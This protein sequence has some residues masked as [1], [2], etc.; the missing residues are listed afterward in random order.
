MRG[1][2]GCGNKAYIENGCDWC[3]NKKAE[4]HLR[5]NSAG[6]KDGRQ[7]NHRIASRIPVGSQ[8]MRSFGGAVALP[9]WVWMAVMHEDRLVSAAAWYLGG[10]MVGRELNRRAGM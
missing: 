3:P 10:W 8:E 6:N 4:G 2:R 5:Q 7:P 1:L 9:G